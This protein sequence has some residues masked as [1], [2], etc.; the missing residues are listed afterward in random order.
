MLSGTHLSLD[1]TPNRK[2]P[3]IYARRL[4][5]VEPVFANLRSNKRLDRFSYRGLAKV[6]V[7]WLLYCLVHNCEKLAHLSRTYGPEGPKN[8]R[9]RRSCPLPGLLRRLLRLLSGL[10][11]S[12]VAFSHLSCPFSLPNQAFRLTP[13]S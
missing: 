3:A 7:Q 12:L 8:G 1:A 10:R 4:A 9:R 13:S 2:E 6:S 11:R 5:I